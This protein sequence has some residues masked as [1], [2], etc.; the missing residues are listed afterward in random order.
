MHTQVM[1]KLCC[2]S[3]SQDFLNE[4]QL[5]VAKPSVACRTSKD[6]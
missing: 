3:S 4:Q 6:Q 5:A 2:Y 1:S